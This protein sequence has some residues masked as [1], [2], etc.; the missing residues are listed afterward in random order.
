MA[1]ALTAFASAMGP[2]QGEGGDAGGSS[3]ELSP[4]QNRSSTSNDPY[5]R[6]HQDS[7]VAWQL[8][9]DESVERAKKENKLILLHIGY[10]ACHRECA[11]RSHSII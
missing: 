4:L 3:Q 11:A 2:V 6:D 5:I 9:D 7:L 1:S 10:R 8:L